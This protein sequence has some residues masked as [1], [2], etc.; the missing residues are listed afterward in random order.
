MEKK[1]KPAEM[2]LKVKIKGKPEQVAKGLES[3]VPKK[4][5]RGALGLI[6]E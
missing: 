6:D 1:D 4:K 2:K 3:L 5:K